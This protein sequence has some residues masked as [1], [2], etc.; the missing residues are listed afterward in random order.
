MVQA[1]LGLDDKLYVRFHQKLATLSKDEKEKVL[2]D[3]KLPTQADANLA[4]IVDPEK[5]EKKL[6]SR[7][8]AAQAMR[9]SREAS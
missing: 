2:R 9:L 8:L 6:K 1:D 7:E 4:K 3:L 5:R